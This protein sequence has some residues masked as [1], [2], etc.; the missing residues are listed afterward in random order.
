MSVVDFVM[1]LRLMADRLTI[2]LDFI[3]DNVD[4]SSGSIADDGRVG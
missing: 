3:I 2:R 4:D 1:L